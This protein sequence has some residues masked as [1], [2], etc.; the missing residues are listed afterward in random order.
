[1]CASM[2]GQLVV[3]NQAVHVGRLAANLWQ[4]QGGRGVRLVSGML[5][6]ILDTPI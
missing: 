2:P 5:D 1:M 4:Q 3:R 6:S